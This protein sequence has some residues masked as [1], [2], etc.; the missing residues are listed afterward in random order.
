VQS[1]IEPALKMSAVVENWDT[2]VADLSDNK[3]QRRGAVEA[4]ME[5]M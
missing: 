1:A 3:R 2:I 4:A 5:I